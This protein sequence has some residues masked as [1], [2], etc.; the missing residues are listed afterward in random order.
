VIGR[1]WAWIRVHPVWSGI[2]GIVAVFLLYTAIKPTPKTYT[3]VTEAA[4]R[5]NVTRKVSASGKLRALNTIKVGA[6]VS[7]QITQV[8]V[9]FNSTVTAGQVLA[10][11]DPTRVQARVRQVEAQVSLARAGLSQAEAA[12]V[13]ARTDVG[14]QEREYARRRELLSRDFISKAGFDVARGTLSAA[15][16]GLKT[17]FAQVQSANAQIQQSSAELSSAQLDLRRTTIVAPT[18]GVII[19][20]LVEPGT[21]VAASFQTPNLFEIAADITRMQV[22]AAVD[23]ADIGQ[24]VENQS[25]RF[26][27]DSYPNESFAA[28]VRQIRKAATETA[29]V[30]SYLVILE[31]NNLEGK[32]L[33]GMTANVEI[34]TGEKKNVLR[35]PTSA[36]RFRPRA[37]DRPK[38]DETDD[39][40]KEERDNQPVLFVATVDA[41]KPEQREVTIGLQGEDFTEILKGVEAGAKVLVRSK[42]IKYDTDREAEDVDE[43][44]RT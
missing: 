23:E 22:E 33:P 3:Y 28:S 42:A 10:V 8:M 18:G 41:Y 9:D 38:E 30:V 20:K 6:E 19:N 29:N 40:K 14:I 37:A 36:L 16:A 32:L 39:G 24:I 43:P 35:V 26:T 11:I 27:V 13:R 31:V 1:I 15:Q 44:S 4:D 7:G 34:I 2:I 21:T 12:V 17:A 5:G 25:V